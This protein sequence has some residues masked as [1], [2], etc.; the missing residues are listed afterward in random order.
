MT[1]QPAR[2]TDNYTNSQRQVTPIGAYSREDS[3]GRTSWSHDNDSGQ[4]LARGM[5]LLS[6]GIGVALLTAPER[7]ATLVGM[8]DDGLNR[9]LLRLVGLREIATGAGLVASHSPNGWMRAR[10][11]GDVMDLSLLTAA[12]TTSDAQ[13]A[14]VATASAAVAGLMALDMVVNEKL[15]QESDGPLNGALSVE[16]SVTV[17]RPVAEVYGFWR[18]FENLPRFMSHLESVQVTGERRSHWKVKA[19]A[20][21][22]AE[23]DAELTE[24]RPNELIA[25]QSA[26]GADVVNYGSVRFL[27]APGGRGTEVHVG[28]RYAP[29]AGELGATIARIFGENP[30]QQV[31]DDLR[32]FKQ[33][34]E[35]GEVVQ[36]SASVHPGRI[37]H[38]AQPTASEA[39][40]SHG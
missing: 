22:S 30:A 7:V 5:G 39:R 3:N 13:R 40:V 37:F 29:P 21:M 17:N 33:V 23:W 9:F 28:L 15:K 8:E 34:M 2:R 6:I 35:T 11:G 24:D 31:R 19:P 26:E 14:R 27:E 4:Q 1:P 16:R 20:G 18:D 36:S 12:M 38:P 32:H 10:V 25:W